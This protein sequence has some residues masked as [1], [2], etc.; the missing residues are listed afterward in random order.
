MLRNKTVLKILS[1]LIAVFLWFYVMGEVNPTITQ[2]IENIPVELLNE[3]TLEQRELAIQG[4][5]SF[6]V[7]IIVEGRRAE[8]NSL[9]KD[10]LKATADLFG[11]EAGE[12][13][14]PVQVEVP[15]NIKLKEIKTPKIEV[16]LEELISVYK[17]ISVSFSG[18]TASGTEPGNISVSPKEI[19][20]KGAKSAVNSVEAVQAEISSSEIT[21][22]L[23]TFN[24]VPTAVDRKGEPVYDV[25]LSAETVEVQAVLYDT[26]TVPLKIEVK[27]S[28]PDAYI[29]D[30]IT[31]PHEISIRGP[32]D[33]LSEITSVTAEP[34]DL[35]KVTAS[36]TLPI[37]PR[38]PANVEV[39]DS[40]KSE[41]VKIKIKGLST[42][43]IKMSTKDS[44]IQNLEDGLSA[45]VNTAEVNVTVTGSENLLKQVT[46][47]DFQISIDLKGLKK[48]NHTVPATVTSKK[49]FNSMKVSPE[50]VEVTIK[51]KS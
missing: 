44:K 11:Y 25:T 12:N 4:G 15:E 13:Y 43:K 17:N 10:E 45:Y 29:L 9:D 28:V 34:V 32:K 19:E 50:N 37:E 2:T 35:S 6:A 30:D 49:T 36:A 20:V 41:G 31:I 47:E 5:S 51:R 7:D 8:L 18:D 22:E 48:G 24:A 26:K 1:L 46:S 39:A 33:T 27:G 42:K 16:T 14:V 38:L 3:N 21:D 23:K 40:S